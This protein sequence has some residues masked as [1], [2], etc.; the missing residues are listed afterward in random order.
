MLKLKALQ[1]IIRYKVLKFWSK[2]GPNWRVFPTGARNKEESNTSQ[3]FA[4]SLSHHQKKSPPLVDSPTKFLS[5]ST[6]Y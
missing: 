1:R 6:K 5:P 3:K 4:H 2:L